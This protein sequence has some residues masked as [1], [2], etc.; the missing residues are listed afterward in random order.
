MR[1]HH[2]NCSTLCPYG[3]HYMDGMTKGLRHGT[4]VCHCLLVESENGLILIDTGLGVKD[5]HNPERISGF[6]RNLLRPA[7]LLQE[8]A[9]LQIRRLGFSPSDVRHIVLTHLDFDHAGGI[10]DFPNAQV[11]LMEP[12]IRASTNRKSFISRGRY[13]PAQLTHSKEWNMY[14]PHGE[15]W[16]GFEAVRDLRGLPPEILMIPLYGHTEGHAGIA[17]QTKDGWLLHA[18]DAYFFR[19]EI[20]EHY[21][22]TPGLRAYQRMMEVNRSQRLQNQERLRNL[23]SQSTGIKLFSAHDPV[24]YITLKEGA[25]TSLKTSTQLS[26]GP[27]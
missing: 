14:L 6:F 27:E 22:C 19:D 5:V 7:F 15:S 9:L 4:L 11:H 23:V 8:T 3:G 16:M 1:I 18:G 13:S 17:V 2:L 20:N 21:H 10:D 12:E 25:I 24:E 26:K